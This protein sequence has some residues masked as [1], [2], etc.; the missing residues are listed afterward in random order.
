MLLITLVSL[1]EF[2]LNSLPQMKKANFGNVRGT[3]L[4]YQYLLFTGGRRSIFAQMKKV[5]AEAH[6]LFVNK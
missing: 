2:S 1:A 6:L 3:W 4:S 5:K